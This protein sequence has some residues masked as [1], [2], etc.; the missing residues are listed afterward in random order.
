[1]LLGGYYGAAMVLLWCEVVA[2]VLL[3]VAMVLLDG[4]WLVWCC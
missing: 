2:M 1:M 3:V 4:W